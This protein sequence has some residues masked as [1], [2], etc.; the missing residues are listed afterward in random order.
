M[1]DME[2]ARKLVAQ[3]IPEPKI[4]PV[5]AG[6]YGAA[7]AAV[8]IVL[9]CMFA[10][11]PVDRF[12]ISLCVVAA[13]GFFVPYF[14]FRSKHNYFS[15]QVVRQYEQLLRTERGSERT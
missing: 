6:I 1:A 2:E 10:N 14:H 4:D 5:Q 13:I 3:R 8:T 7:S 11:L 15:L 12:Q 9:F